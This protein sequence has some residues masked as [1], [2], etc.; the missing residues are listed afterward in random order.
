[1]AHDAVSLTL[2]SFDIANKAR[3]RHEAEMFELEKESS[4]TGGFQHTCRATRKG[5]LL[6]LKKFRE[7]IWHAL[8]PLSGDI[9]FADHTRKRCKRTWQHRE[10]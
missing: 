3:N 8:E 5:K 10:V 2:E 7:H 9:T 4:G 1:M 6:A